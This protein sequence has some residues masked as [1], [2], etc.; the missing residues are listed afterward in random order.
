MLDAAGEAPDRLAH[1]VFATAR[2]WSQG[3]LTDDVAVAVVKR[4]PVRLLVA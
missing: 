1:A 4:V 2:T 3:R